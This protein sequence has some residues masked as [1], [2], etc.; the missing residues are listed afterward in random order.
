V[1]FDAKVVRVLIASPGDTGAARKL[2]REIVEDWNGLNAEESGVML[3]PVM[4]ERDSTPEMGERPQAILNR[5]LVEAADVVI[6]VF[7]TRLG[8]PTGTAESGTVEEIEQFIAADRP[9]LL[10]F[11]DQPIVP[12]SVDV[13]EYARLTVFKKSLQDRGLYD[14]YA[15]DSELWRKVSAA[16]TRVM[17]DR[18]RVEADAN[19]VDDLVGAKPHAALVAR[20]ERE[21]EVSGFNK[22]GSPKYRTRHRLVVVNAGSAAAESLRL[23]FEVAP[24]ADGTEPMVVRNDGPV[25]RLVPGAQIELPLILSFGSV[26]Q[27]DVVLTWSEGDE[28]HEERQTVRA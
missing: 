8:T 3:L 26:S 19:V 4:W 6:G 2:L 21:R 11:S 17:R 14:S 22:S 12:S 1:P 20:V 28:A 10:Y 5:Q 15:S 24:D 25:G 16:L 18:F 13:E 7:W 9:T 27:W 23:R